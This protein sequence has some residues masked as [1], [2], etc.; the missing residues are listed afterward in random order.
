MVRTEAVMRYFFFLI[1]LYLIATIVPFTRQTKPSV[2]LEPQ[3][4]EWPE[5]FEGRDL[6]PIELSA[7]EQ[8]FS[9]GFPGAIARFTDGDRELI[10]RVISRP[11]RKLHPAA[12]CLRGVGYQTSPLPLRVDSSGNQWGCVEANRNGESRTVCERI[13]DNRGNSWYDTSSWFWAAL[14]QR[15]EAPWW[16]VT[17]AEEV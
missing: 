11:S 12:D 9:E 6:I 7:E 5:R 16:S 13:Y 3:Q 15:T 14:M 1:V 8:K 17:V 2:Q 4:I 10:M